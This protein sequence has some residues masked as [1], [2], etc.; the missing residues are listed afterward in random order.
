MLAESTI[1]ISTVVTI[2]LGKVNQKLFYDD[3]HSSFNHIF[4][5]VQFLVIGIYNDY[6]RIS[7]LIINFNHCGEFVSLSGNNTYIVYQYLSIQNT[8]HNNL[9]YNSQKSHQHGTDI[10]LQVRRPSLPGWA[11]VGHKI[12]IVQTAK[13]LRTYVL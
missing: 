11:E 3:E 13:H 4:N 7:S 5:Y 12:T 1:P 2:L 10:F 6:G 8:Y 9:Q